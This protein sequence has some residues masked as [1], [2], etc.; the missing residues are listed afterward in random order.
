[1]PDGGH[2]VDISAEVHA[3]ADLSP[4]QQR[5]GLQGCLQSPRERWAVDALP[6]HPPHGPQREQLSVNADPGGEHALRD[7]RVV[8]E[9]LAQGNRDAISCRL[10]I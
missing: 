5:E 7:H 2:H 1:M 4:W 8:H 6:G 3:G 10:S 9:A